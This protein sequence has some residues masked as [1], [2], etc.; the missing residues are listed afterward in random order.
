MT[1]QDVRRMQLGQVVGFIDDYNDRIKKAKKQEKK[2]AT[3]NYT[4]ATPQEASALAR[5]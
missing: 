3:K 4:F 1:T 5:K 2:K